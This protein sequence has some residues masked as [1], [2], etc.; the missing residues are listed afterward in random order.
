M[1]GRPIPSPTPMAI[2]SLPDRPLLV[3]GD[4]VGVVG[5]VDDEAMNRGAVV[6]DD[7]GKAVDDIPVE[8]D[9]APEPEPPN[10]A[11]H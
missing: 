6:V 2:L 1:V 11:R 4:E 5:D 8:K 9:E 3:L 10:P 7:N